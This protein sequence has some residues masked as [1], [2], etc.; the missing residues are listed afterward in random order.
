MDHYGRSCQAAKL[1]SAQIWL[2]QGPPQKI[3]QQS[4]S[5]FEESLQINTVHLGAA[6]ASCGVGES[7]GLHSFHP[8]GFSVPGNFG[9]PKRKRDLL[10]NP[11]P[12]NGRKIQVK[13]LQ[14]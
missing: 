13:D 11:G 5:S 3:H 14:S 2:A 8:P 9:H 10:G 7:R 6:I 4:G 1:L 12:Q